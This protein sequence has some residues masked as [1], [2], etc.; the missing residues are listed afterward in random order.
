MGPI[1]VFGLQ[2]LGLEIVRR[3]AA[4]GAE[5]TSIALDAEATAHG[6]ELRELAASCVSGPST[7]RDGVLHQAVAPA[8]VVLITD[9]NDGGNADLALR[10]R[11]LDK[12]VPIIVRIFDQTLADYLRTTVNDLTVLS[13]AAIA[14]PVFVDLTLE[15]LAE[16]AGETRAW[17]PRPLVSARTLVPT[18]RFDRVVGTAL[19]CHFLLIV[20]GTVYF[21]H[22][23]GLPLV[24]ALY[25]VSSTVTTVG[26]GDISLRDAAPHAK[27]AGMFL[28][29][30]GAAFV[31]VLFA[32][33][34][35]WIVDRR[36]DVLRG[37]VPELGRG[38]IVV[39]GAGNVGFRVASALVER[40]LRIVVVERDAGRHT[41][42]LRSL[43]HHVIVG[44]GASEAMLKLAGVPR[45]G[46][47]VALTDCDATNLEVLIT[48]R[49]IAPDV[50]L[51]A[52][53]ASAE[54]S[55]HIGERRHARTASSVAIASAHFAEIA[56]RL[57]R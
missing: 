44:D 33:F 50:P 1:V 9:D 16:R 24:D 23:L 53:L 47:V 2:P 32:L 38:H 6:P 42:R 20:A 18:R 30:A 12:D 17:R 15:A 36:L 4:R 11:K 51:I 43:G 29:F 57:C 39:I 14:A 40:R 55:A 28:M 7:L 56:V 52:R 41:S 45:A 8:R 34:T 25:F 22:A 37:R 49:R 5:V 19:A 46:A 54:L 3:L 35:G 21:S 13:L 31:G 10:I 27:V 48:M 26:Y